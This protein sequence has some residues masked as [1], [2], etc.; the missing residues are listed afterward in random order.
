[1]ICSYP[2]LYWSTSIGIALFP[3]SLSH[4]EATLKASRYGCPLLINYYSNANKFFK[5][6]HI[7]LKII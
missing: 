5:V 3:Q 4:T 2:L 6:M 7:D 1:M